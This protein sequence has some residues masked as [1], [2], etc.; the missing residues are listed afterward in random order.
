MYAPRFEST[1]GITIGYAGGASIRV[2]NNYYGVN[3]WTGGTGGT[4][5]TITPAGASAATLTVQSAT[6]GNV[7]AQSVSA[8]ST[9]SVVKGYAAQSANLQEWQNSAS[10]VLTSI[11]A[12]GLHK[13]ASGNEQTTVGAA[14]A[15]SALPASPTK[16]LKI[17]GSDGVTYVIP[18]FAAS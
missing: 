17:V 8:A 4:S 7:L 12:A 18:A 15:A 13:W 14:G 16:Y 3:Y 1:T 2:G 9:V 10:T 6:T 11:T 5:F